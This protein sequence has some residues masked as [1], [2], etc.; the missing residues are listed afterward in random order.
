VSECVFTQYNI[1]KKEGDSDAEVYG[2]EQ[3]TSFKYCP[4]AGPGVSFLN[5][6]SESDTWR[7]V[8]WMVLVGVRSFHPPKTEMSERAVRQAGC[9]ALKVGGVAETTPPPTCLR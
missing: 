8:A 2:E 3:R 4:P 9:I 1:T 6:S 5:G 7:R